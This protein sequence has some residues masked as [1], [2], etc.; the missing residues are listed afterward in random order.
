MKHANTRSTRKDVHVQYQGR[1]LQDMT[2]PTCEGLGIPFTGVDIFNVS[3]AEGS[4]SST[5]ITSN[6][7]SPSHVY[8]NENSSSHYSTSDPSILK[9]VAQ[10]GFTRMRTDPF[11]AECRIPLP[12]NYCDLPRIHVSNIRRRNERERERVRCVNDGYASLRRHLP[13]ENRDKRISKVETLKMAARYIQH[14]RDILEGK[15]EH[16]AQ[17]SVH[18]K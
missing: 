4:S 1:E 18:T 17:F 11:S 7:F 16:T 6:L 12:N 5:M 2:S 13:L 15:L 8:A 14:M 9:H 3:N 10:P